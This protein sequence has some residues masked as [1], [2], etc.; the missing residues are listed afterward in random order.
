MKIKYIMPVLIAIACFGLQQAKADTFNFTSDHCTNNCG[1]QTSFGTVTLTQ[2]GSNVNVV[3]SLLN[4]NQFVSTGAGGGQYFLFDDAGITAANIINI[5]GAPAGTTANTGP[6]MA[7]GTGTWMWGIGCASCA[8]GAAGAF[9][10]PITFTVTNTT[11]AAM[12]VGH[13]VS[14]FGVELF[15]ADIL[16]G[17]TGNTGDVDVNGH[18]VPDGGATVMLLGT[19]LGAL[20]MAR[21]FIMS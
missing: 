10:G 5:A 2:V 3:V 1:P 13:F 20:G 11:L 16:S 15:V 4:G 7:D 6:I 21:R 17:T 9:T 18:F 14:G 19:A 12:E 8:Q